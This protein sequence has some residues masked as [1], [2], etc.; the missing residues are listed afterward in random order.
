V[1]SDTTKDERLR[2]TMLL[3]TVRTPL[4]ENEPEVAFETS[5]KRLPVRTVDEYKNLVHDD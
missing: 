4:L 3:R 2:L 5:S 1:E